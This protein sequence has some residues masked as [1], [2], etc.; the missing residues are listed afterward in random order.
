MEVHTC[1][2]PRIWRGEAGESRVQ[3]HLTPTRQVCGHPGELHKTLSQKEVLSIC[4]VDILSP[5]HL[6]WWEGE[7]KKLNCI[8][9]SAAS[10]ATPAEFQL[11]E[12]SWD[13]ASL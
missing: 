9:F 7:R 12:V 1:G 5:A 13:Q 10:L 11:A 4:P 6:C 2:N 3:G 8:G